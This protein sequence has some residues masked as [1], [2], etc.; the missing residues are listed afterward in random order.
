MQ[1]RPHREIL[2]FIF[3]IPPTCPT[4]G[5]TTHIDKIKP[6]NNYMGNDIAD[7]FAN[8]VVDGKPRD[9]IY[10]KGAHTHLGQWT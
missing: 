5:L 3:T 2:S 10:Y 6:H 7:H 9:A 8:T 4:A 1:Q